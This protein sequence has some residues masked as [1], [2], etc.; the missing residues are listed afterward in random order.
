MLRRSVHY[1]FRDDA[2][3]A[4][5]RRLL[6]ALAYVG[7]ECPSVRSGD[8]GDDI[9]GGSRR[10]LEIPP[11]ERTPRFHARAEGPPSNYDAALHLDFDDEAGLAEYESHPVALELAQLAAP[12]TVGELTA[13]VDWTYDGEPPTRRGLYRHSALFV[14]RDDADAVTRSRAVDAVLG[15]AGAA[16]VE[17]VTTGESANGLSA[18]FDWVLDVRLPDEAAAVAFLAGEPYAEAAAAVAAATKHE[19]TTRVTHLMRGT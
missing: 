12:V 18:D 19:W 10:L 2:T 6:R 4:E 8:Y 16:G 1:L 14:C 15:L 11:W 9:A 13:R 3:P 5:R 7:L 17:A